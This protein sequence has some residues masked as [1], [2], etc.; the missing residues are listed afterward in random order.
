MIPGEI[1]TIFKKGLITDVTIYFVQ[2]T[3]P[4]RAQTHPP[5]ITKESRFSEARLRSPKGEDKRAKEKRG[6]YLKYRS[7]KP[8]KALP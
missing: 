2:S 8:L 4:K 3:H 5:S 7:N 6:S 1:W